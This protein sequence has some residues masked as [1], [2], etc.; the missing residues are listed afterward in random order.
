VADIAADTEL[1]PASNGTFERLL[2][3]DWEIWGPNGGYVAALALRAAGASS[4]RARPANIS[5]H[6]LGVANF[7]APVVITP[8]VLR[9]ARS[10]TSVQVAITQA[11]RPIL[12]ALVWTIDDGLDGLTHDA[13]AA[14]AVPRWDQ[15]PT[16]QER[17]RADGAEYTPS[18]AFWNNFNQRPCNWITDWLNRPHNLPPEWLNWLRFDSPH[19][20]DPWVTACRQLLLVDLGGWPAAAAAYLDNPFIAPSID[21]SC[22]F[23]R[24]D[25][26]EW[27]L[28]HGFSDHASDGLVASRQAIWDDQGRLAASGIS[29]LLCRR[30][31]SR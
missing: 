16:V 14:P 30:L 27:L 31:P 25:V 20:A 24:L 26:G 8:L 15:L 10:A 29:H 19:V 9:T 1:T 3:R 17:C 22:E 5:V 28:V 21:V 11:G 23:H 13:A 7:D 4:G 2:S 6:F 12:Q 18:Y